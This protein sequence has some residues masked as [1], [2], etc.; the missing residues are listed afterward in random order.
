[1]KSLILSTF[2]L[3]SVS[4]LAEKDCVN[5]SKGA[6]PSMSLKG[7]NVKA[8]RKIASTSADHLKV[9]EEKG[10]EMISKNDKAILCL[11]AETTPSESVF[12]DDLKKIAS[13]YI[14]RLPN[15]AANK[16]VT[17][18]E[19]V[20][21]FQT[22]YPF[23]ICGD[24]FTL[25][26]YSNLANHKAF[27]LM[28]RKYKAPLNTLNVRGESELDNLKKLIYSNIG[29]ELRNRLIHLH[30]VI[31]Q[32]VREDYTSELTGRFIPAS[33]KDG[34][35]AMYACEIDGSCKYDYG[36]YKPLEQQI[37]KLSK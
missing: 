13:K 30:K 17:H 23:V 6:K 3:F 24:V 5:C 22:I 26:N 12:E 18:E 34:E 2:L 31:R 37:A 36:G 7:T 15:R 21:W 35:H 33:H 10:Y 27:E 25:L 19:I 20:D 14:T 8:L 1:L 9:L 28:V 29:Q 32:E 11:E 16:P 4:A